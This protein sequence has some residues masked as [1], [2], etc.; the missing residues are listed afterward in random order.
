MLDAA[1]DRVSF[2]SSLYA[3]KAALLSRMDPN[4]SCSYDSIA[5]D[6]PRFGKGDYRKG[7]D[8]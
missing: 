6:L 7:K 5:R 1:H 4:P 8:E 3:E 2:L